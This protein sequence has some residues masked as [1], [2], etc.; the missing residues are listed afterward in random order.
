MRLASGVRG[1]RLDT[2]GRR[3]STRSGLSRELPVDPYRDRRW[4]FPCYVWSLFVRTCHRHYPGRLDGAC[5]L[6]YLHRRRLSL[7]K[8][9]VGSCNCFFGSC[10]AFT[11][12][13][14]CT[15]AESLND[16]LHRKLRQL[17]CLP[18][19]VLGPLI[20]CLT[21]GVQSRCSNRTNS[22]DSCSSLSFIFLW[23]PQCGCPN[24]IGR[25]GLRETSA[26]SL[27]FRH[28]Q[29]SDL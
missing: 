4:G 29:A 24:F 5:S 28:F 1:N 14:A 6:V 21:F 23:V 26:R 13:M 18:F 10:S 2:I 7:C 12:V 27:H 8:S 17:R 15:L 3:Y 9:Q 19:N 16:P 20:P 22:R 11:H 25:S